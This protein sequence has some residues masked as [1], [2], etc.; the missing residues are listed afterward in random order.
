[1]KNIFKIL[2]LSLVLYGSTTNVSAENTN[3]EMK[4]EIENYLTSEIDQNQLNT[5]LKKHLISLDDLVEIVL[6]KQKSAQHVSIAIEQIKNMFEK[7]NKRIEN[8]ITSMHSSWPINKLDLS[9]L[10]LTDKSIECITPYLVQKIENKKDFYL[11]LSNNKLNE[12]PTKLI[13][14]LSP[15]S[16]EIKNTN[17]NT[18]L[19]EKLKAFFSEIQIKNLNVTKNRLEIIC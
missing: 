19:I 2:L 16:L 10:D 14:E 12:F 5:M 1:M 6:E 4:E 17:I 15:I 11:D 18:L 9:N 8:R 7:I 13:T 3:E